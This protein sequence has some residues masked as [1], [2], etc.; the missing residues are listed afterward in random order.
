MFITQ[1]IIIFKGDIYKNSKLLKIKLNK[2]VSQKI[3]Q[4]PEYIWN[5][6]LN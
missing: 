6:I 1:Y 3:F 4:L 5:K 2:H